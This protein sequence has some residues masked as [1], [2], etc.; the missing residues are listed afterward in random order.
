MKKAGIRL[1]LVF[2]ALLLVQRAVQAHPVAQGALDLDVLPDR[3][4]LHL[5]V[6]TE[7]V[8]V[9]NAFDSNDENAG[10]LA[11]AWPKHGQY[12]LK[13]FQVFAGTQPLRG[14]LMRTIAP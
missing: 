8:F 13:H 14:R 7:E 4:L 10:T 3:I 9:A 5:R 12:L 1:W 2:A 6:S 11:E